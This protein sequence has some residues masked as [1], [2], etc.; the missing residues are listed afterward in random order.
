MQGCLQRAGRDHT[1]PAAVEAADVDSEGESGREAANGQARRA[2]ARTART[3]IG[4][5]FLGDTM[6]VSFLPLL[7]SLA[8]VPAHV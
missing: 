7:S 4:A 3:P 2:T 5:R 8:S 1:L 6:R